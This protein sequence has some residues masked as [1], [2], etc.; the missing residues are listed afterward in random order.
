VLK[1][2]ARDPSDRYATAE[3]LAED[4]RRYLLDRPIRARRASM[5]ERAWR[6]CR[7]NPLVT[8]LLAAAVVLA[9]G[10]AVLAL[11]LWEKQRQTAAALRQ[12]DEQRQVAERRRLIAESN[13]ERARALLH[14]APLRQ[15]L[16]WLD[17]V[18]PKQSQQATAKK[19]LALFRSLLTR[20]GP[21]PGDR[22]MTA[23]VHIELGN[24][25]VDLE[26][27]PEA[28]QEY[29]QAITLLGP[30]A[31]EFPKDTG[32]RNSLAHCF[33]HLAWQVGRL[34]PHPAHL[35]EGEEAYKQ[36]ISLH[37]NLRKELRDVPWCRWQ[38]AECW[39]ELGGLRRRYGRFEQAEAPLRRAIVLMGQLC[40]EFSEGE[41]QKG[42]LAKCHADLAWVLAIRPDRRP[43]HATEA[44]EHAQQA[45]KLDPSH[46]DWFHT[47]GV[48][49]CRLGH[50]KEALEAIGKS[51]LLAKHT[52]PPDSFDRFFEAMAYAGLGDRAQAR[53]CYDE[54]VQ[55]MEKR[56]P[57]HPDLLR[58]RAEAAQVLGI[59]DKK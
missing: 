59:K 24:I 26:Q 27:H 55:W 57:D 54:A 1:A 22:L 56:L 5:A 13:F 49:H 14:N 15:Q 43:H 41:V 40:D 32:F 20:P 46:H 48:A 12:V 39:N 45:I 9:T 42:V 30:L 4:F 23:Q 29:R 28:A 50:W 10:M 25:Y 7:R 18:G 53:R 21:D 58:F 52:G 36:A 8:G 3:A 34:A 37:E 17:K 16:E 11:L 38:L 44:L 35:E 19:A 51:R 33:R 2:M 6:W 31:V 47:L